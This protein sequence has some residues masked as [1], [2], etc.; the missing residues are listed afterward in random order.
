M[1]GVLDDCDEAIF[2][3]TDR[4]E[5]NPRRWRE[6]VDRRLVAQ[7]YAVTSADTTTAALKTGYVSAS[8]T[9]TCCKQPM[10]PFRTRPSSAS[11]ISS[12]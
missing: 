6:A 10:R 4:D 1:A 12:T 11:H 9:P 5:R 2:E 3:L 7:R 8:G